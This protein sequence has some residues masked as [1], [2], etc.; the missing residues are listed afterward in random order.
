MNRPSALSSWVVVP[1]P[2]PAARLRLICFPF[3]GGGA[4]VFFPWARL[5]P[6]EVELC[7]VQLP[8]REAR[9]REAPIKD[10]GELMDRL[11]TELARYMDRPYALFGHSVGATMAFELARRLRAAGLR[12]PE[13]LFASGR[14]APHLP[15]ELPLVHALPEAEFMAELRRLAGTPEE[16]LRNEELMSILVPLL[17]AD[18]TLSETYPIREEAPLDVPVSAYGGNGD[19]RVPNE[20]VGAWRQHT[21]GAFRQVTFDGGHFFINEK[22]DEVM[23]ELAG[24]LRGIVA[25]L[26]RPLHG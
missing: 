15:P 18:F 9:L 23:A 14:A 22:R 21:A 16:V 24:E 10:W 4:S 7:A 17:R 8:G 19:E 25:G 3:A 11:V 26:P 13:H 6:A 1:A 12:A 20:A 5:V 2:R